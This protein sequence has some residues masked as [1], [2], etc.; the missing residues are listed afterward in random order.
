MDCTL[1]PFDDTKVTEDNEILFRYLNNIGIEAALCSSGSEKRVK[2][3]ADILNVNYFSRAPK[4][5]VSFH[6]I[7]KLFSEKSVPYNTIMI[8]DSLFLDMFLAGRNDMPKILV[9]MIRDN[10]NLTVRINDVI[11]STMYLAL[12]KYGFEQKKYYRGSIER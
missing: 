3:V 10:V 9:D 8:G 12:K 5:F 6:E 1:L 11:Q 4:P 7:K 2:P